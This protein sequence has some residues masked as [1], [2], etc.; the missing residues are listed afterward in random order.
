MMS[1]GQDE[2]QVVVVVVRNVGLVDLVQTLQDA[3]AVEQQTFDSLSQQLEIIHDPLQQQRLSAA[4]C[5]SQ[6]RLARLCSRNMRCF[7]QVSVGRSC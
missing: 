2:K 4:L 6:T 5:T 1:V 7:R 3:M